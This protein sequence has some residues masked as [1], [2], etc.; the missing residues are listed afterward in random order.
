[1]HRPAMCVQQATLSQGAKRSS[2]AVGRA[3][4]AV[5]ARPESLTAALLALVDALANVAEVDS[6]T[7]T[8][9][10]APAGEAGLGVCRGPPR[11]LASP[12]AVDA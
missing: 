3:S 12:G 7:E 1:M 2:L 4:S 11:E 8:T 5:D 6:D 9:A 10:G